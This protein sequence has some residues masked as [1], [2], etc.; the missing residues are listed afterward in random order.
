VQQEVEAPVGAISEKKVS[1]VDDEFLERELIQETTQPKK[2]MR[3]PMKMLMMMMM[4]MTTM[5]MMRT[6]RT[7]RAI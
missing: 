3:I 5:R 7:M 1:S 2:V 4:M 6:M